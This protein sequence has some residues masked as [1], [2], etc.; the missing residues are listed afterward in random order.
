MDAVLPYSALT[1]E[2]H[3]LSSKHGAPNVPAIQLVLNVTDQ[4]QGELYPL[5]ADYL[6]RSLSE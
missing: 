4:T 5:F 6:R 3:V 1:N 2:L